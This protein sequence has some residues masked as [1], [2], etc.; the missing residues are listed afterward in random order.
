MPVAPAL[1]Y[2]QLVESLGSLG[3]SHYWMIRHVPNGSRVLDVGCAGGYL[4]RVLRDEK[5]CSV[6]GVDLDPDAASRARAVCGTVSVGSLDDEAFVASLSGT[7]DRII[8]GDVLEHLRDPVHVAGHLKQMLAPG[9]RLIISIPNVANWRI[10]LD[11]LRGKF[12]YADSGLMDRTHLRF[13]TFHGIKKMAA[14]A[15]LRV[16]T[17]E[18]T[19]RRSLYVPLLGGVVARVE[20]AASK[21]FPNLIA[22]QTLLELSAAP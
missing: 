6:D 21:V 22:Y 8:C 10:R 14:E 7:Y 15:G 5:G 18:F 3:E 4:A 20:R 2:D 13:Y 12:N 9:G 19:I 16:V 1:H 17:R 11:L